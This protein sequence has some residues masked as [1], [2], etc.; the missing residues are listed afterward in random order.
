MALCLEKKHTL[1]GSVQTYSCELV[2]L[3]NGVGILRYVIDREYDVAGYR[4]SPGD[5]TLAVYWTGRPYTLYVWF[6]KGPRDRAYYFNIADSIALSSREFLWRDLAVDIL[7]DPSGIPRVLDEHELP[8][9]L[10]ADLAGYIARARD[11]VL[12]RFRD[13]IKEADEILT[14]GMELDRDERR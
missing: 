1:S 6:R 8:P 5:R 9:D 14:A 11:H 12:E 3:R 4:L 2:S 10:P 13:I 7:V